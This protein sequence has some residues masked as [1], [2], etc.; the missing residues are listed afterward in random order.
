MSKRIR[1]VHPADMV[2]HLWAHKS[3]L[4]RKGLGEICREQEL[5]KEDASLSSW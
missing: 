5:T 3:F 1:T 4:L 2:A